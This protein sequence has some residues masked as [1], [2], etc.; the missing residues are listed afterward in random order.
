MLEVILAILVLCAWWG[1]LRLLRKGRAVTHR[2]IIVEFTVNVKALT[3]AFARC[4]A[5]MQSVA[6][7]MRQFNKAWN[8]TQIESHKKHPV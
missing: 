8:E 5:S 3:E 6:E 4:Q 1:F 2:E 7:A